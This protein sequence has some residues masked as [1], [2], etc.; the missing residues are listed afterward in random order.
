MWWLNPGK[1]VLN[2]IFNRIL[3]PYV[4]NLDMNQLNYGIGQGQITL[5]NLR[6][7]KGVLDKLK[8]PVDVAEGHLGNFTL[9]LHWLNLGNQPV[10]V[11]IED[12][13]LLVI[14]SAQAKYDAAE[15]ADRM[16]TL[17]MARVN[18]LDVK[19]DAK[20]AKIQGNDADERQSQGL[21]QAM[22]AKIINNVQITVK[23]VHIRYEDKLSVPGHPFAVGVTLAGFTAFSVN[24][25][26]EP[27]F[28]EGFV[29]TVHKLGQLQS[30]AVYFDT[31][32]P[33]LAGLSPAEAMKKFAEM[34]STED[35]SGDHQFILKPISGEGRASIHYDG[36]E[37]CGTH[38]GVSLSFGEVGFRLD[39][40]QYRDT[41]SL[42]E[43]YHFYVRQVQYRKYRPKEEVFAQNKAK[44]RFRFALDAITDGVHE[45][46]K[47]WTWE[48]FAERRQRRLRYIELHQ[49][50]LTGAHTP[51]ELEEIDSLER[52]L[53]Y[54]DIRSYRSRAASELARDKGLRRRLLDDKNK[55]EAQNQG[56]VG[57]LLGTS[58][59]QQPE[60]EWDPERDGAPT[61]AMWEEL[62]GDPNF[63]KP[64][65][66]FE[67]EADD[68][69]GALPRDLLQLTAGAHLKK[70][71]FSLQLDP[72]GTPKDILSIV[73]ENF[74]ATGIQRPDNIEASV[75]LGN[76]SVYD[77]TA[78]GT[79][80]SQIVQVKGA[81]SDEKSN[82][83]KPG[84]EEESF[85]FFKFEKNP[86]NERADNAITLRLR[87]MEIVYNRGYIEAIYK[88]FKPPAS[89]LE[90]VEALLNAASENLEAFRTQSRAV[91]EYAL[92]TSKTLDI[93]VDM[94]A[95]IIIIPE[96][97]TTTRCKHLIV[98]AGHIAIE[99]ELADRQAN[100]RTINAKRKQAY[101]ENDHKELESMVYD[102]FKFRLESAQFII[103]DDLESCRHALTAQSRDTLHLLERTNLEFQVQSS[104]VPAA[105]N[106]TRFKIVGKLPTLHLN[107]SDTK[108]KAL[109]RLIDVCMPNFPTEDALPSVRL[110]PEPG[111]QFNKKF[112]PS[113]VGKEYH[114]EELPDLESSDQ[115]SQVGRESTQDSSDP[116]ALHHHVFECDFRVDDLRATI[117]KST[118]RNTERPL[119]SIAFQKFAMSIAQA[120][121]DMKV[122]ISLRS[123]AMDLIQPDDKPLKLISSSDQDE[124]QEGD[125]LTMT[126]NRAQKAS[127]E[128]ISVFEGI[129]QHV[130]IKL[131]TFIF[132]A[133]PEAV[134]SLY[135]FIMSTFVAPVSPTTPQ[136][137]AELSSPQVGEKAI[138]QQ[139]KK[140]KIRVLVTLASAQVR[141]IHG[142]ES[143]ATL[144]LSTANVAVLLHPT[145]M[146]ITGKL[147]NLALS[148]DNVHS[149]LPNFKDILSIEGEN[150]AEFKYETFDPTTDNY[151]GVKS[152]VY[153]KSAS[154][155]L[156]FIEQPLHD[157][158]MFTTKLAQLK[159][160]YDAATQAAVQRASEIERMK[161]DVSVSTPIL[162]F[163]SDPMNSQ[164]TLVMRLGEMRAS[165]AYDDSDQ[166]LNAS[167]QGVQLTS[168]LYHDGEVSTLKMIDDINIKAEML[169][170]LGV[171]YS[172]D[173]DSPET[174][175]SVNI[176]DIRLHLTQV[177]YKLLFR[178]SQ[179]VPR[180]FSGPSD[181][182]GNDGSSH[183][184]MP[185]ASPVADS[186]VAFHPEPRPVTSSSS[187]GIKSKLDLVVIV[188]AIKLHLYDAKA[189]TPSNIKDHGIARF[190]L[191]GNSLRFKMLSDGSGEAQVVLQSFTITNTRP[192]NSR[193]RE[194]IP[195]SHHNRNQFMLLYTMS[196][197]DTP[198]SLAVLTV[199]APQIIFSIDPVFA[200]LEFV[201][202]AFP[203][204]EDKQV[205]P[206]AVAPPAAPPRSS[207]A[208]AFDFRLDL[209]DVSISVLADDTDPESQSIKLAIE[210]IL[211]AQ[212]G[213]LALTINKL[214]MSL[215]R[216]GKETENVRFLDDVDL[217]LSLDSRSSSS[218]QLSSIE[219]TSKP[220]VLRASY[221]DI[222]LIMSIVNKA[223][224]MYTSSSSNSSDPQPSNPS[225]DE[226]TTS[227]ALVRGPVSGSRE[228]VGRANVVTSKEQLSGSIDGFRLILIGDMHE[229]PML[230]LKA[231]FISLS[232]QLQATTTIAAQINY[233]NMAN[234]HWEPL[235]DPWSFT[236]SVRRSVPS[237]G[238]NLKMSSRERL[239]V[240]LSAAFAE[241]VATT[242][243]MWGKEGDRV[244]QRARGSYA[245]YRIW[246]RTGY[247]ISVWAAPDAN[248]SNKHSARVP[249]RTKI[250]H[251]QTVDWR[252]GD[253]QTQREHVSSDQN[254]LGIGFES[255][256]WDELRVPVDREGECV[257]PLQRADRHSHRL[258]C[259]IKVEDTVKVVVIRSTYQI[260]NQT[261]YP[262]ELTLVDQ[263]GHPV[264]S[265]EKIPPGYDYPLPIETVGKTKVRIQPDQGFGYK[266]SSAIR[267]EDL[268]ARKSFT[269]R[270]PHTD[271]KE[272]AFRFQAWAQT[273]G[274]DTQ[275]KKMPRIQ[276]KLRAP[277][278]LE[279]L[280][281]YNLQYRVY[282]KDTDQNWRSY[283]RKGGIMPVHCVELTHLVLLNIEVQDTVFKQSDFAIVNTDGNSDF[284]IEKRLTLRDAQGRKLEL[285]L[286]YVRYP[287]SG[288]AFKVQIYS[289]FLVINK[290]GLPFFVKSTRIGRAGP[291]AEAA[292][293]TSLDVLSSTQPFMLSHPQNHAHEFTFKV[294]DFAWSKMISLEAPAA[295]T[296]L[297]M[298]SKSRKEE[299]H[300]GLAWAEGLGKYKLT[301]VITITPR[302]VLKNSLN[303]TLW[304]REHGTPIST[305]LEPGQRRHLNTLRASQEHLLVVATSPRQGDDRWSPPFNVE[306]IG[307][308]HLRNPG[309][310][311][312]IRTDIQVDGSTI[313]VTFAAADND[314]PFVIENRTDLAFVVSQKD[315]R[316]PK[317]A[318]QEYTVQPHTNICY[319]W[320]YPAARDKQILLTVG[321]KR[322]A[323]DIMEI[324]D[325]LP[326]MLTPP[327]GRTAKGVSLDIRADGPKQILRITNYNPDRSIYKPKRR[328][329]TASI[330][331]QE[332]IEAF[333]VDAQDTT[334]SLAIMFDLAGIGISLLNRK[335]LE[336]LYVS[337]DNLSFGYTDSPAAQEVHLAVGAFQIDNQ[338]HDAIYP[339]V[340]QPTPVKKESSA[341]AALPTI[342]ASVALL[343]DQAHGVLYIKYFSV[344]LQALTIE[345]DEDLL[346]AL[347]DLI[348]I[349]GV[350]WEEDTVDILINEPTDIPE[351]Q[352]TAVG[353]VLYFEVLELQPIKLSLSFMRTGRVNSDE[354]LSLRN[355]LAV[356]LNALTMTVGNINDAPVELNALGIKDM[357][358]TQPELLNRIMYHYRQDIL[359]QLY[360]ILGSADFIGNPVGLFTN[361]S[362]GVAD[363]FYEPF[364]GVV[365]HGNKELGIG[366]AKGA[367]SFVKKTVFGV[368]DSVTKITSSVGKGLSAATFDS[369]YQARRRMTQRR[370]K[371]RHAIYGVAAGGEAFA[372]SVASAM[373]GVLMKPIEGAENEG[374]LGF[375]KGVGKGA[376]SVVTK[377]IVG[378]FDLASNVSEGI[379]NTT[380]VFDNPARDRSRLPRLV[381]SDGVLSPYSA[382]EAMGQYW[383]RDLENGAYRKESYVAHINVHGG[384]N[385]VL[386]TTSRVLSFWSNKLKLDWDLPFTH[387]AGVTIEDTGI[388]FT[389]KAGKEQDKFVFIPDKSS[390]SWFYDQISSVVRKL[391]LRRKMD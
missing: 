348:Q 120:K 124:N 223:I 99:S 183:P 287:D 193:F 391:N 101:T 341:V 7:K 49:K 285:N 204:Q 159:G 372:S 313:F 152:F 320:D 347:Y 309:K 289:P 134:I 290:A 188:D 329:S 200:L 79:L 162:I 274:D 56:W 352:E 73:F 380:T 297:V 58:T 50:R 38:S 259:E 150:F 270:C 240:N 172:K 139:A 67:I 326:F 214:G 122:D 133:A 201:L 242:W 37:F 12:V 147:G 142:V 175:L 378:V 24:E 109:M 383:M 2:R 342:Q 280:L 256:P 1:E 359:R 36:N 350:S 279:N 202:S 293:D 304:V 343:K 266:W 169:Q 239:D 80:Y 228:P 370:N 318:V 168:H 179:A 78:P 167:L 57:W 4:E 325:L 382:R 129:D 271:P 25:N 269:I 232:E 273:S 107:F 53:S 84:S 336:V 14:P 258:L 335:S 311:G 360:R 328:G 86:L 217:T 8:L 91:L 303:E 322:R 102:K 224:A 42:I 157:L 34:I 77:Y 300:I 29:R 105:L 310:I 203:P 254:H 96:S 331:Q 125:L 315:E 76:F 13:Y 302:F 381:P 316:P 236:L 373:E 66:E 255:K 26:W 65:E 61:Q 126:Y 207:N 385:V 87:P 278:E 267:W 197:G 195:A 59:T 296:A 314:W 234:S 221:R 194:I 282:D 356:V 97:I 141:F 113:E 30:L 44:A 363:I 62:T 21:I 182:T 288:G 324:G 298:P 357:R 146:E 121:F 230:H 353:Q 281:P 248:P 211:I 307:P 366:I 250:A 233:W 216:M 18:S 85:F 148:N 354:K 339:V 135:D 189:T 130:D 106:I 170:R 261:L 301:K 330:R 245:P 284:D 319:A 387:V 100:K 123:I 226:S 95:P 19:P 244:L 276:L 176:S 249:S 31:D 156:Y 114:V 45:H 191:K 389:H 375:F 286:N 32:T 186:T 199:D 131:S 74:R 48:Y 117:S 10:E 206:S 165:N 275:F 252:F 321:Q 185:Q 308:V 40:H 11:L 262:L 292:G 72:C 209:H 346:F 180:I 257:F 111:F 33:S 9:S 160:L 238:L 55:R 138:T 264:S 196:G 116:L 349:K 377:P 215:L 317:N 17:K 112:F 3:A 218:Q 164:D 376:S 190:A 306:D 161:F 294:G 28:I 64:E 22:M 251:G 241:L 212:Q 137:Q 47:T 227:L 231:S 246:N 283:L 155:K 149:A 163:P 178:L 263:T 265:I 187:Q 82:A 68:P 210:H 369:E 177:Q 52:K 277:L 237:E 184:E 115:E 46:N 327:G 340:L 83:S 253:W 368:S 145:T 71:T 166:K 128:F 229:Q 219:I 351:P 205:A 334:P 94:S 104:I 337:V 338:L 295:E 93:Q 333:Q 344:L 81:Q 118:G 361:V 268:I 260:E 69:S 15:E 345:A 110:G 312:L 153:L 379:R 291:P 371:P 192:G 127:P 60:E 5:R 70:G 220:I 39:E 173:T 108:Y 235:I 143:F 119:G 51:E 198:T 390:Q 213:I 243:K 154:M 365:M 305:Q 332:G 386:L 272:A 174:Q 41:I 358:L 136:L 88:F 103:G 388:R 158:Y 35:K 63:G 23:N 90:S 6:L 27:A 362:S 20:A 54:E 151:G 89:Q 98:D 384:D 367:A 43:M 299:L 355:P 247:P 181:T 171:E 140:E 323:I 225:F 364:N 208:G 132:R 92:E 374:A 75:A 222:T 16:H 144:S